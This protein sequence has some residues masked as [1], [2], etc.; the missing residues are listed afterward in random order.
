MKTITLRKAFDNEDNTYYSTWV[1]TKGG[2]GDYY[3][4]SNTGKRYDFA[5]EGAFER[6]L[7]AYFRR[8]YTKRTTPA[9]VR[10][11]P[12]VTA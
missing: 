11:Q 5:T 12:A 1:F 10:N 7:E 6:C 9:V 3:A 2:L 8:G 4:I